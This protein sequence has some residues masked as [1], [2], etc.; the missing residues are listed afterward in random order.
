MD[1]IEQKELDTIDIKNLTIFQK[2]QVVSLVE[3]FNEDNKETTA[4]SFHVCPPS[5]ART[6]PKSPRL[7]G[8][9]AESRYICAMNAE[10]DSWK[11]S[12]SLHILHG[13]TYPLG[14]SS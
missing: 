10:R 2:R 1:R 8:R 5:A 6:I 14:E 13:T 11:I 9:R 3:K 7:K 4:D 12:A